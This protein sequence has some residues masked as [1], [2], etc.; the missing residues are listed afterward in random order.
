MLAS[1]T[2]DSVKDLAL[3][4]VLQK[5]IEIKKQGSGYSGKSPFTDEKSG[6]F[7]VSPAKNIWKCFSTGIGGN[8]CISFVMEYKKFSF[9]EAIVD[10]AEKCGIVVEY[11]ESDRAKKQFL[12]KEKVQELNNI[13]QEALNYFIENNHLLEQE[14]K[15]ASDE[16]SDK[17][18]LGFA[19]LEWQGI[20]AY[21]LKKGFSNQQME[22][23]G[24]IKKS[25]KGFYDIFRGRV[26]FPIYD[27]NGK[28][29]GFSGRLAVSPEKAGEKAIKVINSKETDAYSKSNSLLGIFQAKKAITENDEAIL[30]EGNYDV[31]SLHSVGMENTIGSLGTAFTEEQ[32][33]LI[34]RYTKNICFA[35]DN[36]KAGLAKIEKNTKLSL[37]NGFNVMLFIPEIEGQ[38]PDDLVKSKN[39]EKNEFKEYYKANRIESIV[40]L[41]ND[42]FKNCET[43]ID[44]AK[45]E[46]K[47]VDLLVC[48]ADAP[49]R[50]KYVKKFAASHGID[51]ATVEKSISISLTEKKNQEAEENPNGTTK[52]KL[53]SYLSPEDFADWSE[54]GFYQDKKKN[55]IGYYFPSQGHT[56]ERVSNFTMKPLFQV[57]G[58]ADSKR[59]I[60][61]ENP[62][63]KAIIELP[64]KAIVGQQFFEEIITNEGNFWFTGTKKHFQ[65][66]KIKL[67]SQF[68]FCTEIRTLGWHYEGF[69]SFANGVVI[70]GGFKEVNSMGIV[71]KGDDK[72]FLPA[73]SSIYKDA[74]AEDDFYENDRK[75]IFKSNGTTFEKWAEKF[76]NVY[77]DNHN[78]MIAVSFTIATLFSDYIFAQNNDF[79]ILFM[80]GQPRTG[81]TTCARSVSRIFKADSTPFNLNQ[82][83]VIGFQRRLARARNVIEHL[84][85]YQNDLD[86]KRFQSLKGIYDRTG[87][88]KG[89]MTR[90]N[91]TES[92]KIN[93]AVVISGQHLPTRDGNSLFTRSI[94]LQYTKMQQEFK[95]SE[96]KEFNELGDLE[97]EGLS[98]VILDILKF[99][100]LIEDKFNTVQFEIGSIMK[101]ELN[102]EIAD[103]RV[104]KNY[105]VL[106]TCVKIL[107]DSLKFPFTYEEFYKVA[108]EMILVQ[109]T[110][111]Q[112]SDQLAEF[113]KQL[114]F[115]SL[116]HMIS[117][118]N[119]YKISQ[120]IYDL[121]TGRG[122]KAELLQFKKPKNVLYLKFAK[123]F[124]LYKESVRRQG[125]NGLDEQTILNYMKAH[126][127]FLGSIAV[128]DFNGQKTSAYAFD[129]DLLNISLL[130]IEIQS[131]SY[132]KDPSDESQKA[133]DLNAKWPQEIDNDL[134]F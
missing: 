73:F 22:E 93:A 72:Y 106:L 23:A 48:V 126:K 130:G 11:D 82:G 133:I 117:V 1:K 35:V 49:L 111:I 85:E 118:E 21:L 79:P 119:D 124:P 41:A 61:I 76:N 25:E 32:L 3:A 77:K 9:I 10:I 4:E 2:I 27:Y 12:K 103:G 131:Q 134:P 98:Q 58:Q 128:I 115:L 112:E 8:G 105:V 101:D 80:F 75:F 97:S 28:V 122:A 78:G 88:E 89:L 56:P 46:Q 99:R 7:M 36:D 51:K 44:E 86:E 33:K 100:S 83:T 120:G 91:R 64:N 114:E 81:K 42:Y 37:L 87:H 116:Q 34:K 125:S 18:N 69:F 68:P 90:D 95:H 102:S 54:Y 71:E 63:K 60:E 55:T 17:F 50:N 24:L 84:D 16:I 113:F 39:W 45:A 67:L 108:K 129:F 104:M 5:Y 57:K 65:R 40:Y 26:I 29:L 121:K 94:M 20:H 132:E 43:N 38:D 62:V 127:S 6:S 15:R 13:N 31:T 96:V 52:T 70:D 14:F 92:V 47:L 30:V 123:V 107:E 19:P 109:S 74:Q 53:P 66:L 59:F 110:Q